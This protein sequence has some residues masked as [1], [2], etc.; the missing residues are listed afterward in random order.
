M[1]S[2]NSIWVFKFY[3]AID[4]SRLLVTMVKYST[5]WSRDCS[6]RALHV[7]TGPHCARLKYGGKHNGGGYYGV[8]HNFSRRCTVRR[9]TYLSSC[10]YD[11]DY[12]G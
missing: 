6:V 11:G 7:G 2:L 5:V 10:N 8:L 4:M 3:L 9:T 12:G 1:V